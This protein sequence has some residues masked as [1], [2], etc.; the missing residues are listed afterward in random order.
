MM[1][2]NL[3][4]RAKSFI[5]HVVHAL[6]RYLQQLQCHISVAEQFVACLLGG[7]SAVRLYSIGLCKVTWQSARRFY[8]CFC[9]T[10][11]LPSCFG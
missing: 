10:E 9:G 3:K 11:R 8:C 6:G 4:K 7:L 1:V 5:L 2:R